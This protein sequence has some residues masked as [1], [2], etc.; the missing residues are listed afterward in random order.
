M[1]SRL[2]IFLK[3]LTDDV[4][5]SIVVIEFGVSNEIFRFIKMRILSSSSALI[6][7]S[8]VYEHVRSQRLSLQNDL[9]TLIRCIGD[10]VEGPI[11]LWI[12]KVP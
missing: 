12:L 2:D 1:K 4:V 6:Y 7:L 11:Y 8:R 5:E 10:I 3:A 9:E